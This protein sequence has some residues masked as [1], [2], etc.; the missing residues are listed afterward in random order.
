MA[1]GKP[2][3]WSSI[4][5]LPFI[6]GGI[7][8]YLTAQD[9]PMLANRLG[10]TI[11]GG[12]FS[13]TQI[14]SAI[15]I[16]SALFGLSIVVIGFYIRS[17][18]VPKPRMSAREELIKSQHPSQRVATAKIVASVPFLIATAYV[19][20][21]TVVPYVYPTVTFLLGLF[22]FSTG[23]Y[24]YWSNTL[25]R[26]YITD[27]RVIRTF[28]FISK[29]NQELPLD[30]VRGIQERKSVTEAVVGL[31]NVRV[32]SGAGGKTLEIVVRN[33]YDPDEFANELR[34]LI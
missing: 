14:P 26:Y 24:R 33:I 21:Y 19:L 7:T 31:G 16:L 9:S 29:V 28:K 8:V 20:F 27:R 2:A 23:M 4:V 30:K 18:S 6:L 15:G 17:V 25:T 32:A 12:M 10:V 11:F 34:D 3:L 22:Y 1:R 5:A 13:Y